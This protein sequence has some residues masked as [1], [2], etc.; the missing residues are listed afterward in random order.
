MSY[1]L[2]C[3]VALGKE[4]RAKIVDGTGGYRAALSGLARELFR[5]YVTVIYR[6]NVSCDNLFGGHT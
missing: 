6:F 4:V 1:R 5:V 2:I 3:V